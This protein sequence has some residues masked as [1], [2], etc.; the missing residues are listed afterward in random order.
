L[1]TPLLDNRQLGPDVARPNLLTNGGFEV[2]QRGNGPFT[3]NNAFT[4]DRW[5]IGINGTDSL[6]VSRDGGNHDVGSQYAANCTCTKGNGTFANINQ[7]LQVSENGIRGKTIT[8]SMRVATATANAMRLGIGTNGTGGT[9]TYSAYHTGGGGWQTLSVTN[10]IPSDATLGVQYVFFDLSAAAI[11]DN[12][13]L[14]IGSQPANYVPLHPA[15]D[16][17][18]CLRY[19]EVR[20]DAYMA[21]GYNV[22][23]TLAEFVHKYVAHKGGTP[24][25]TITAASGF[26]VRAQGANTA[27]NT[28][29]ANV[30]GLDSA[31]VQF[32]VASGLTAGQGSLLNS[33]GGSIAMEW[34]P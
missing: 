21:S 20:S 24:T 27:C 9:T 8:L 19:Y 30:P 10:T 32:T 5:I 31:L 22:N 3:A 17:N 34:N 28:L 23:T 6:G 2:W 26:A 1:S 7:T 14:V 4:A 33:G 29:G 16:L 13:M 11:L 25:A 15:D 12:A 18:R